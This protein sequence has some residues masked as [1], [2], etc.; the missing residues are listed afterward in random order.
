MHSWS[1]STFP[2]KH[3][4]QHELEVLFGLIGDQLVDVVD[5]HLEAAVLRQVVLVAHVLTHQAHPDSVWLELFLAELAR[6]GLLRLLLSVHLVIVVL[7]HMLVEQVSLAELALAIQRNRLWRFQCLHL[8]IICPMHVVDVFFQHT[9][10]GKLNKAKSAVS[11]SRLVIRPSIAECVVVPQNFLIQESLIAMLAVEGQAFV[12]N[13]VQFQSINFFRT[14]VDAFLVSSQVAISSD[15]LSTKPAV[16]NF[17]LELFVVH[18]QAV[19]L[20]EMP[21]S[22]GFRAVITF[23]TFSFHILAKLSVATQDIFSQELLVTI[24]TLVLETPLLNFVQFK[25]F[26]FLIA[27]VSISDMRCKISLPSNRL[28]TQFAVKSFNWYLQ[29]GAMD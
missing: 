29:F 6:P 17:F 7:Q 13:F 26:N 22:E 27:L 18:S 15:T 2:P 21:M 19:L 4:C 3:L 1:L 9:I 10:R 16:D 12:F 11:L 24:S 28:F 14:F 5:L 20:Q 8:L 23:L 25:S